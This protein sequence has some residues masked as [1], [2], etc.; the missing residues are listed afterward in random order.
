MGINLSD[1]ALYMKRADEAPV[2][3]GDNVYGVAEVEMSADEVTPMSYHL[4]NNASLSFEMQLPDLDLLNNLCGNP[5]PT[6]NFTLEYKR[7]I[8]IQARWHKKPRINKK[9][10]K[11]FGMK[12]DTVKV[13]V[14]ANVLEYHPGHILDEQYDDNGICAT[15]NSFEFEA[16]K[17]EYIFRPD[18][19]RRGIK[20][21]W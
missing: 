19:L 18:Q 10:L 16:N 17:Q 11:R 3:L 12:P 9:W 15:F 1:G 4:Y 8:M 5:V 13:C 6:G 20:I 14:D 2:L 7:P 21:E